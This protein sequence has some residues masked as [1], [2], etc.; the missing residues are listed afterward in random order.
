MRTIKFV[1]EATLSMLLLF[2]AACAGNI[3]QVDSPDEQINSYDQ[4]LTALQSNEQTVEVAGYVSQPF[5]APEGQL[6]KLDGEDIQIFE[7]AS[8]GEADSAAESISPD[9]SSI[10]T[11]MVSWISSP[12]FYQAGKLIVLYVGEDQN[13]ISS[14]EG[15]L[16]L[17]IAGR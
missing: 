17:Q 16:G 10:G 9:G 12:H 13:V 5:F 4:L 7:F 3:V 1:I 14:L 6:I 11:S 8:Q 15:L 2:S